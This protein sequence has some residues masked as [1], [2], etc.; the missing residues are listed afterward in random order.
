M[1][2][3]WV[4]G[5]LTAWNVC[6][7]QRECAPVANVLSSFHCSAHSQKTLAAAEFMS[8]ETEKG[9][10]GPA[11]WQPLPWLMGLWSIRGKPTV[12]RAVGQVHTGFSLGRMERCFCH[13]WGGSRIMILAQYS[14]SEN[15]TRTRKHQITLFKREVTSSA[16]IRYPSVS[17]GTGEERQRSCSHHKSVF[18]FVLFSEAQKVSASG[19]S[20]MNSN[21][22][23]SGSYRC[24]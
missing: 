21:T 5:V 7:V 19:S 3:G 17:S 13:V 24:V 10:S 22:N 11:W 9:V 4:T 8:P 2:R 6:A 20:N 23:D 12:H 1:N 18:S 15:K 16:V 14:A